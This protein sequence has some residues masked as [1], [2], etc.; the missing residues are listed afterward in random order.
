MDTRTL[1]LVL[2]PLIAIG[3]ILVITAV[4]SIAQK[5]LSWGMK[6]MWLP[7]LLVSMIGPIIYFVVGSNMLDEKA[8]K[9][10][11]ATDRDQ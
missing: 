5:P 6:W 3:L 8:A 2:S 10:Q 4:I 7:L 1:I 11:E 9:L